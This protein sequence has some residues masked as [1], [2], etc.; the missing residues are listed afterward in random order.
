MFRKDLPVEIKVAEGTVVVLEFL[1]VITLVTTLVV[2]AVT[3][4]VVVK[5]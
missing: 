2:V 1:I 3:V 4:G 5:L